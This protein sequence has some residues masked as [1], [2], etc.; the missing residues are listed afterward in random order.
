[1]PVAQADKLEKAR[2]FNRAQPDVSSL[3]FVRD[4]TMPN[5]VTNNVGP[6][7]DVCVYSS[8]ATQ[9]I[10]DINGYM[11]ASRRTDFSSQNDVFGC[12]SSR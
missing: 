3:N 1:V 7:V 9:L 12:L 8:A 2:P 4:G 10:A 6:Y 5:A 11:P